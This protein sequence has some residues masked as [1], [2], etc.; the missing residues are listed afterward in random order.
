MHNIHLLF[1]VGTENEA[2]DH[3]TNNEYAEKP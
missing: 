2:E 3:D 1:G